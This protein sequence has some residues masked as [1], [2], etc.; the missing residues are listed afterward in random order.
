LEKFGKNVPEGQRNQS[1]KKTKM[2]EGFQDDQKGQ[3]ST[4]FS[5]KKIRLRPEEG[6]KNLERRKK[7][8]T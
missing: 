4:K 5:K 3:K 8:L 1:S 2:K 7:H 6:G